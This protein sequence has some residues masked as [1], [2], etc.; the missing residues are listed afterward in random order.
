MP[1]HQKHQKL[2][3]SLLQ[4]H[5]CQSFTFNVSSASVTA[6]TRFWTRRVATCQPALFLYLVDQFTR[7]ASP[8]EHHPL[9]S[10]PHLTACVSPV[11]HGKCSMEGFIGAVSSCSD[12]GSQNT[13]ERSLIISRFTLSMNFWRVHH[14]DITVGGCISSTDGRR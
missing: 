6:A 8:I 4:L 7:K 12:T 2:K 5:Q 10:A 13:A 11:Y 9:F 3:S 14:L 1:V